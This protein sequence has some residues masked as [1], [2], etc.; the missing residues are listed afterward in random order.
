MEKIEATS[1]ELASFKRWLADEGYSRRTQTDYPQRLRHLVKFTGGGINEIRELLKKLRGEGRFNT[2]STYLKAVIAY[3]RFK[4]QPN[5]LSDFKFPHIYQPKRIIETEDLRR[6]YSAI[7]TA[8]MR[9]FFLV[10]ASSGLRRGRWI[11]KE[12]K[13]GGMEEQSSM[14]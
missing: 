5:P 9:A 11:L 8:K 3:S 2:Y 10:L 13:E 1:E 12:V 4:N 7:K 6:F 14:R